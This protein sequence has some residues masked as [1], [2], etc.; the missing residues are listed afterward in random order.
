MKKILIAAAALLS[1][2]SRA[3]TKFDFNTA[4][5]SPECQQW[6]DSVFNTLT[7]RQRVAQLFVPVV[8]PKQGET[9]RALIRKYVKD[10]QVGGLLFRGGSI[11][12]Y[13]NLTNYA[14][15]LAS[16]PVLM[17]LDGEW[18]IAMRVPEAPKYPYNMALGAIQDYRLLEEYGAEVARECRQMGL[19]V[20]FAPVADVNTNPDNPVIGRRS[21]GENPQRVAAAVTAFSRG[22]ESEGVIS[23]AKHFPGHGDTS[24]DS[25]KALPTVNH[26]RNRL[27]SMELLPFKQYI[28]A[29]LSSIMVGHLSVPA[30]DPSGTPA[31]M[32]QPITTGV[33]K[34]ELGFDG[35]IFTDA[36]EM[37]GADVPGN[38]ALTAFKAGAGAL[39]SSGNPPVDIDIL[40]NAARSGE[41][42]MDDV[43]TRCRKMLAYKWA[44]GL[45]QKPEKINGNGIA[46]RL[47]STTSRSLIQRLTAATATAVGPAGV[48]PLAT[49][50]STAIV[51]V[52]APAGNEFSKTAA[53]HSGASTY[54][55]QLT[56]A[57]IEA[58]REHDIIV[59]AAFD[60]NQSTIAEV[61][62]L[63][64]LPGAVVVCFMTPYKAMKMADA[65]N[66]AAGFL[67][68][69]DD[70]AYARR[71]AGDALYGAFPVTG[72]LPVTMPGVAREGDG[73]TYGGNRLCFSMTADAQ[74]ASWLL[75]S[76]NAV[77]GEGVSRGAFTGI[78]V[79]VAHGN[80]VIVNLHRGKLSNQAAAAAVNEHSL[81]DL[82]SMSKC[83]GTLPGLMK[84]Y[85]RGLYAIDDTIGRYIPELAGTDKGPI[86]L[87]QLFFHQS[88]MPAALN[89]YNVMI[90]PDSYTGPLTQRRNRAPYTIRLARRTYANANARLRSD[91]VGRSRS[92]RFPY[93]VTDRVWVG[94]ETYDTIM[95]RIYDTPLRDVRYRYSCLNFSLLMDI[96][97]R[98]TGIG[99]DRWVADEIFN[100]IG[101]CSLS[102]RPE[103]DNIVAT[104]RDPMLRRELIKGVVH[105]EMAAFSGGV[106]GNAGLFGTAADVAKVCR[107]FMQGGLYGSARVFSEPTARLFT[108]TKSETCRRGLGFD[109]PDIDD[110]DHSPCVEEVSPSTYGHTGFTGTC[111]WIDPE[112]DLIYVFLSNR[113]CP[114]REN[115][116]WLSTK[117]RSRIHSLIYKALGE[118]RA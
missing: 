51:S 38:H 84:A 85:D 50:K 65:L 105:D 5:N 23:C 4:V 78:Q 111:F 6:V 17:T 55:G 13:V 113:V 81:F 9:S 74:L 77:A 101:A 103:G 102:Y 41:V 37:K 63:A 80:N 66:D 97:Q 62:R 96:E 33:L 71:A 107:L 14:Q 114:S 92:E 27:N 115:S 61:K 35:L 22:M 25:H 54:A 45:N 100:P 112:N 26:D 73:L 72:K 57:Q 76:I 34:K 88:G 20:D 60:D 40:L 86:T 46:R 79:L 12:Q 64:K 31:S 110:P 29:G 43:Y 95:R 30:L 116:A 19:H 89:M 53:M 90:D 3:E 11:D 93:K 58:V 28:D 1:F 94:R 42:S 106:Q 10:N 59:I 8:D 47:D 104:E 18:G 118:G 24:T 36:L 69:Y 16:I 75:D 21:F 56:A 49:G 108:T 52:G 48:F 117:A 99:H 87:R 109:R 68:M 15:S 32:S 82:A 2:T 67:M 39:L 44:C 83:I 98:L 7:D 91:I 70:N